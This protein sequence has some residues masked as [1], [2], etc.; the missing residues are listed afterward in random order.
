M[1]WRWISQ[2]KPDRSLYAHKNTTRRGMEKKERTN[3][4]TERNN[5]ERANGTN[6]SSMNLWKCSGFSQSNFRRGHVGED[7]AVAH[8]PIHLQYECKT[9]TV[10]KWI[11]KMSKEKKWKKMKRTLDRW[12]GSA[13]WNLSTFRK[14]YANAVQP[15]KCQSV[16]DDHR[17]H[18]TMPVSTN[19]ANYGVHMTKKKHFIISIDNDLIWNQFGW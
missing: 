15:T 3:E 11:M 5:S 8:T 17:Y 7:T 1:H 13:P 12:N 14:W 19:C 2:Q 16:L 10:H 9:R 4:R 18:W 6:V